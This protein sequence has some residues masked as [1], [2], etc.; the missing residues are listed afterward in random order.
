MARLAADGKQ[1]DA[2]ELLQI[3][4]RTWYF[5]RDNLDA[6][7]RLLETET[8][9]L[10]L[11]K[12]LADVIQH[13]EIFKNANLD[14]LGPAM[15][16]WAPRLLALPDSLRSAEVWLRLEQDSV[17]DTPSRIP[18]MFGRERSGTTHQREF[19][20]LLSLAFAERYEDCCDDF[21]L[22]I[23][24]ALWG[25]GGVTDIP[26]IARRRKRAVVRG[27]RFAQRRADQD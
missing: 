18:S 25:E 8:Y 14:S 6:D 4:V 2:D 10:E 5:A 9:Y 26:S 24:I 16:K 13:F 7:K 21:V 22:D 11:L 17:R 15:Q 3:V 23:G 12:S 20:V 1:V 19:E 27:S